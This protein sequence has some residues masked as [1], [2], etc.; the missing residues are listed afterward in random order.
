[1]QRIKAFIACAHE[2]NKIAIAIKERLESYF[3]FHIF[4][5]SH[6]ILLSQEW[7]K[8][9]LDSLATSDFF[10][11]LISKDFEHSAFANQESGIAFISSKKILPI[12]LDNTKPSGFLQK[13]QGKLLDHGDYDPAYKIAMIIF[14]LSLKDDEYK[15]FRNQVR[16]SIVYALSVSSDFRITRTITKV[17]RYV[18]ELTKTQLQKIVKAVKENRCVRD[19]KF[20]L[21]EFKKYLKEKYG[22]S[23]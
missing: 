19:E 17:M 2:D 15:K 9:I 13:Y 6:S 8:E 20:G 10:I 22:I 1:M 4:L 11:P 5:Y 21:P 23:L 7:E 14:F 18:E 12:R 16:E 3:G